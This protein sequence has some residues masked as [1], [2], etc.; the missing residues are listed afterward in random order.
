MSKDSIAFLLGFNIANFFQQSIAN[1]DDYV[2]A[3]DK[4][5]V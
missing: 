4:F 1:K 2:S 5:M 3:L